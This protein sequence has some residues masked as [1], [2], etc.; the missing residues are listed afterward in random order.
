MQ[1]T[2]NQVEEIFAHA[3]Q[4][5]PEE[6]CGLLG[7]RGTTVNSVYPLTN[8]AENPLVEYEAAPAD[9]FAAHHAMRERGE[10][11]LGIYHSHPQ[12]TDPAPS[13]T[14]IRR[15]FYR[16]A[17]YFIVGCAGDQY[18]L[19]AFRLYENERRSERAEFVVIE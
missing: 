17:V 13:Q 3:S 2:K 6:C 12:Q 9:L 4:A 5:F 16:D 8:A 18:I 10:Q 19:R 15:A 11:L 14:D 7:G 1:L